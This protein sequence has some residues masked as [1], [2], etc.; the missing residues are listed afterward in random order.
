MLTKRFLI[1][2]IA[3]LISIAFVSPCLA[4][5]KAPPE[6]IT[7]EKIVPEKASVPEKPESEKALTPKKPII[8]G[9]VG[10]VT[11]ISTNLI[12]IKR[13]KESVSFDINNPELKGYKNLSDIIVG[14]TVMVKYKKDGI[15]IVKLKGGAGE[16]KGEKTEKIRPKK[17]LPKAA[18]KQPDVKSKKSWFVGTV[19]VVYSNL[20][21]VLGKK[22]VVT[23]DLRNPELRG[24]KDISEV[25]IGDSVAVR[26][27]SDGIM[28]TKLKGA[29]KT[30]DSEGKKVEKKSKSLRKTVVTRITC[31]GKGPCA[32]SVEKPAD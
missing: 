8:S 10:T 11:M 30:K 21:D 26:Y 4:K 9:F 23:F 16:K 17:A 15:L 32:V 13:K 1:A 25:T 31:T 6:K 20:L 12:Q 19:T 28:I 3:L 24:Y 27:T 5:S 7:Q 2:V 18:T 22:D 29:T 14:D